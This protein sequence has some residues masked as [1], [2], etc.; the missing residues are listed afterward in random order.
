MQ[1]KYGSRLRKFVTEGYSME[2]ICRM[3]GVDAFES[4]VS[5]YPA[6]VL[7]SKSDD[8][9]CRYA[10]CSDDFGSTD[11]ER[12]KHAITCGNCSDSMFF[13]SE[14]CVGGSRPWPLADAENM[15]IV[16]R[17]KALF[18]TIEDSGVNIGIGVATG[19]D[20][21]FITTCKD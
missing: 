2:L 8:R 21:V 16:E 7:I 6:I 20:D 1:N 17:F 4:E 9:K 5:A 18:P 19:K 13:V 3:H 11:V 15:A 14:M 10:V 12:L